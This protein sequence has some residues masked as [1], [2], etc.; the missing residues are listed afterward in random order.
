MNAPRILI[1]EDSATQAERLKYGLEQHGYHSSC[2]RN[3]QQALESMRAAAPTL[4]ISDIVMPEMDGYELC[5]RIKQDQHFKNIPVILLTSL[6]DPVDVV[7]GL[8]CGS[9]NFVFK[10]YEEEYLL[11]RIAYL[12]ANRHL[13]ETESTKMGVEIFFAGRKFFIS[14]DRLQI[15]N[16]LLS[17]YEAAVQKNRQLAEARDQLER[18]NET[19][20]FKV[21]ERTAALSAEI[22]ERKQAEEK[23]RE[24]AALLDKAQEAIMVCDLDDRLIYWNKSAERL[25]GWTAVEAIGQNADQ[26][27]FKNESPQ[28]LQ[29]KRQLLERSEWV[30]ELPQI[31]KGG[32]PVIVESRW[33]LVRDGDSSPKSKLVINTDITERK[34]LEAQFLRAQRMETLGALAGGIAHDLNNALSPIMIGLQLLRNDIPATDRSKILDTMNGS[35][36]RGSEMVKQIVAFARG[37][38]GEVAILDLKH[39]VFEMEKLAKQTFPR[40]IRIQSRIAANL[41]PVAGNAT[42]LH[43]VLLN[44]CVNARD[45]MPDGGVL[46]MEADNVVLDKKDSVWKP[47]PVSG[48]HVVLTVSDTGCGMTAEVMQRVFEPFFT[49]KEI[50]KGT[51]L[52]LSTVQGIVKGHSGFAE[53]ITEAGKGTTFKIY[54]PSTATADSPIVQLAPASLPS[55]HGEQVLVV[56]DEIAVLEMT[57]ETLETFNYRVLM[58]K[59]GAEAV[60]IYQRN[61]DE[62]RAVISDMMMPIMDG[63]ATVDALRKIDPGVR[64]IGI[65]GLGSEAALVKCGKLGVQRFLRKPFTPE[66][67]LTT[68]HSVVA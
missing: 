57:R 1:V 7:S 46:H 48:P 44:L 5:R 20:E 22:T 21:K 42:Q 35:A 4:V 31:T 34:K 41:Y 27:L 59:N 38:S 19:L 54:L 14:S 12:L 51:G 28:F 23:I 6:S 36:Q 11:T 64:V 45:A 61:K 62:I 43:Q 32:K 2:A 29:M 13:R 65:S 56:D 8:E 37:V 53:V 15:L 26:F 52:G 39:L 9:D 55:G 3:G 49:T 33:T 63:P 50:G 68:L 60:V 18:F 66:E 16:L 10:P 24:Q 25:Y 47:E 40:S 67:L 58:A 30:G 17:T